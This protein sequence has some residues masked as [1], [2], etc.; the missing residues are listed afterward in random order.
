MDNPQSSPTGK[1]T[2]AIHRLDVGGSK[3]LRYSRSS[4]ERHTRDLGLLERSKRKH[5]PR[6]LTHVRVC[7][8]TNS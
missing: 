1:P 5:G 4:A 2:D 3:G 6:S 8:C 7:E